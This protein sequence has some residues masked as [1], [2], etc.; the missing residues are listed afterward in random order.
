VIEGR[1]PETGERYSAPI[2]R[3][4]IAA[5][6]ADRRRLEDDADQA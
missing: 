3:E 6:F 4:H 1:D 5:S 2:T